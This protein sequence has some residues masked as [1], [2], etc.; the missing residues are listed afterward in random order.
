MR[1]LF[2]AAETAG[3]KLQGI[4]AGRGLAAF[5]VVMYH[6]ARHFK[7]DIGY[8]P[9]GGIF[10]F[11][12]VGVDFF[13][14]LSGFLI[15]FVHAGDLGRPQRLVRY[16][17][18]RTVRIYPVYWAALLGALALVL[19]SRNQTVPEAWLLL[20][21]M[22]LAQPLG[23][24]LLGVAWT[25]Q[26]EML[27]YGVFA[28]AILNVRL[29]QAVLCFWLCMILAQW[30]A[31]ASWFQ[32]DLYRIAMNPFN[33][34]FFMGMGGAWLVRRKAALAGRP[35]LLLAVGGLL[36]A[37]LAVAENAGLFE[38][39][40]NP[41]RVAYGLVSTALVVGLAGVDRVRGAPAVLMARLGG[42]S[43][44]IYL[45]HLMAIGVGYKAMEVAGLL[46]LLPVPLSYALVCTGAIAAGLLISR[47]I[48]FPLLRMLRSGAPAPVPL[49]VPE[50]S[51]PAR[52]SA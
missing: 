8:L 9:W 1:F 36:F 39:Y 43:Y 33:L 42:A 44:S 14:V 52:A 19:L 6:A 50:E 40:G 24:P 23:T 26:H 37:V 30:A 7:A 34:E 38:S 12:H 5:L 15:Y 49:P 31:G 47:W 2:P 27:F 22:F 48:E 21:T 3:G 41:A 4:E 13:F 17:R 28:L 10:H 25:L 51:L 20:Q 45:F 16:L 18:R 46:R 11:G 32:Q 35:G 29:G